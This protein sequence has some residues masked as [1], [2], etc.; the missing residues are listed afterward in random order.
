MTNNCNQKNLDTDEQKEAETSNDYQL[1]RDRA[2][3]IPKPNRKFI[4][5]VWEEVLAYAYLGATSL[6]EPNTF[7]EA[8]TGK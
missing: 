4:V 7:E 5:N 3:R 1:T 6:T 2:K 8:I